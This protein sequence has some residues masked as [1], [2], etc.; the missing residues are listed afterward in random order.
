MPLDTAIAARLPL[1]AGLPSRIGPDGLTD[2]LAR[3][4]ARFYEPYG[5][6]PD[7]EVDEVPGEVGGPHGAVPVR[8]Y[9]PR[10]PA[11]GSRPFVVWAHGG[12][13]AAGDL[14]M[15]ESDHVARVLAASAGAVV[16]TV[17][18]RLAVG[19]VHHPVPGDDLLAAWTATAAEA[20]VL[21]ADPAQG[22]LGGASAGGNLAAGVALR[23]R[24]GEGRSPARL[25]LAYPTLHA[26]LPE[27]SAELGAK[28]SELP[29]RMRFPAELF[30][31]MNQNYAGRDPLGAPADAFPATAADL[32]GL[33][34]VTIVN[35]DYDDLRASG[36]DFARL[37]RAAGVPVD[38]RCEPGVPHGHLNLVG[39]PAAARTLE[40]LAAAVAAGRG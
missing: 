39:H 40:V 36:E 21:G 18:Y 17:G 4:V 33:P 14:D 9:T 27:A 26:V 15:P 10:D 35:C 28:V 6:A 11:A 31:T 7:V 34:P 22:H 24:D 29:D 25:L 23:L 1:L 5:P 2:E 12:G 16:R 13:F 38:E 20:E 3:R 19:G 37:L 30:A 8:T 32:S